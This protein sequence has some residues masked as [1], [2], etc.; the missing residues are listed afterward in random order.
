MQEECTEA[1]GAGRMVKETMER[2]HRMEGT[3]NTTAHSSI[4]H[5][6]NAPGEENLHV[7]TLIPFK[8]SKEKNVKMM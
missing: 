2:W 4:S 7:L 5:S 3:E 8:K 1:A 6:H